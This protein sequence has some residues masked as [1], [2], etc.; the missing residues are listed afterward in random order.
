MHI[1][2]N[3]EDGSHITITSCKRAYFAKLA[4]RGLQGVAYTF[5]EDQGKNHIEGLMKTVSKN[6]DVTPYNH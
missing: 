4:S 2:T 1:K 5:R 3:S 6:I